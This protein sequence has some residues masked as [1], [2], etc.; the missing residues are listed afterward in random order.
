[1]A[2]FV[3]LRSAVVNLDAVA[4]IRPLAPDAVTL[5][6][7]LGYTEHLEGED[8]IDFL[9][10]VF[11]EAMTPTTTLNQEQFARAWLDASASHGEFEQEEWED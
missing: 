7:T 1:M 2:R 3:R 10:V 8:A 9:A 6:T 11:R 5:I 4:V